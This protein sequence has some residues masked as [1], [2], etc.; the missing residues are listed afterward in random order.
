MATHPEL[1]LKYH[2]GYS[3]CAAAVAQFMN[4]SGLRPEIHGRVMKHLSNVI[5]RGAAMVPAAPATTTTPLLPTA[6]PT[7]ASVTL[8]DRQ[9]EKTQHH[10]EIKSKAAQHRRENSAFSAVAMK[11]GP[12]MLLCKPVPIIP[13]LV[14]NPAYALKMGLPVWRP[15]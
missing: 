6:I 3:E 14:A 1:T 9:A 7:A 8:R 12:P 10:S 2:A 5:G 11:A 4:V 15:W 13:E